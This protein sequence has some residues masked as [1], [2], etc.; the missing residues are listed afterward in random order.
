MWSVVERVPE[1]PM[2]EHVRDEFNCKY[3]WTIAD[4]SKELAMVW[5]RQKV[6]CDGLLRIKWASCREL[7]GQVAINDSRGTYLKC[8][9]PNSY[10]H[11]KPCFRN[12]VE[13]CT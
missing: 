4:C 10:R 11:S 3:G 5:E 6:S 9:C 8:M 2:S 1:H 13:V 7:N 12:S